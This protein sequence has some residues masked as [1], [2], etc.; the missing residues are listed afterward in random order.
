MKTR[1]FG[2]F[3]IAYR[4]DTADELV[5]QYSFEDDIFFTGV[6]EYNLK[7][8]DIV[9]DIGAHIGT[10]S[11]LAASKLKCGRVYSIEASKDNF[12]YLKR[13][14]ALNNLSNVF[15]SNL[16]LSDFKG[17]TRLYHPSEEGNWG[18]S[19]VKQDAKE[20]EEVKTDT[21]T[22]FIR[23]NNIIACDFMK[24]NCEGAEF[25]IILSTPM[26][27][28]E[29][30]KILLILYHLDSSIGHSENDL[31][32]YLKECGFSIT[33]R[34]KTIGRG[35]IIAGRTIAFSRIGRII[36]SIRFRIR[37]KRRVLMEKWLSRT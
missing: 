18:Y 26:E 4:E 20:F 31:I 9:I 2:D 21:L 5:L 16:A 13:N 28:L 29:K 12:E 1:L 30:I 35:W 27:I 24:L 33:L 6:P 22:N 34:E 23:D 10:F 15:I 36:N 7:Q 19:I 11:I 3:K 17:I 14:I 37:W 8:D 25:K 32:K